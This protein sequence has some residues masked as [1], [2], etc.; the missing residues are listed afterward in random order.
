[1]HTCTFDILEMNIGIGTSTTIHVHVHVHVY[2][3]VYAT[4]MYCGNVSDVQCCCL[5]TD[6]L[7]LCDIIDIFM[8]NVIT[9]LIS[10]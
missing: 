5:K 8:Y 3:H 6:D 10:K 7:E 4:W 1:M 9:T 2:V